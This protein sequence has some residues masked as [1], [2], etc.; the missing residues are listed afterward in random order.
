MTHSAK[1]AEPTNGN[2]SSS[3][4]P[5]A[6]SR[7]FRQWPTRRALQGPPQLKQAPA[8]AAADRP[9]EGDAAESFANTLA[10]N[11]KYAK[12][13]IIA[14]QLPAKLVQGAVKN[15]NLKIMHWLTAEGDRCYL[16]ET[17]VLDD[18]QLKFAT[19][20]RAGE[21]LTYRDEFAE[22]THISIPR[23]LTA[24]A[25]PAGLVMATASTPLGTCARYRAQFGYR[26]PRS[27]WSATPRW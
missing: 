15:T 22:A 20:L 17:M 5:L 9:D 12:G 27:P 1:F 23:T 19:W 7:S 10:E 4:P 24:T 18:A 2:S 26:G 21:A 16:G 25:P 13:V 11:R 14:E 8:I 6:R 3:L